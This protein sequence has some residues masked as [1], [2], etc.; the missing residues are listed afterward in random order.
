MTIDELE[1]M[2][3][4]SDNQLAKVLLARLLEVCECLE[5]AQECITDQEKLAELSCIYRILGPVQQERI[6]WYVGNKNIPVG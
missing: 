3:H 4:Q 5:A 2:V 6:L 1:R